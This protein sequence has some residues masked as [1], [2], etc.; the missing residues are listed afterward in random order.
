MSHAARSRATQ[1][2]QQWRSSLRTPWASKSILWI[3]VGSILLIAAIWLVTLQRIGTEVKEACAAAANT[4]AQVSASFNAHVDQTIHDADIVVRLVQYEYERSP[5]TFRLDALNTRGVISADTALQVTIVGPNGDV[6]QTTAHDANSINLRDRPHF[7]AHEQ[8][9][10]LGLYISR[11]LLGRISHHWTLQ[12]TR[13]LNRPDGSFAGVVVVSEDPNFLTTGFTELD[14]GGDGNMLA[15]L[16][17]NGYPLSRRVPGQ[18]PSPIGPSMPSYR[19]LLGAVGTLCSDPADHVRRFVTYRH[20][21]HYPVAVVVGMSASTAM[22]GYRHAKNLYLLFAGL[23]TA[24]LSIASGLITVNMGRLAAARARMQQL[25][26]TDALTGLPNRYLLTKSLH[27]RIASREPTGTLALLFVD[28]DN[29]KRINDAMGHQTGDE[30]LQNVAR[31]LARAAGTDALLARVG[32][33]EFVVVVENP[34]AGLAAQNLARSI[35]GAFDIAFGLRGNSYVMRVSIGI[36]VYDKDTE[37]EFDLLRRADLAMYAAKE[38]GKRTNVS[39]C[40]LYAPDLSTRAMREIEFQQ[41]LQYAID[42]E[43]FFVEYQP[44]VSLMTGR[45]RGLEA[46]VKW[47]HPEKG[48]LA[49]GDFIPFAE[50][51]GFIVPIGEQVLEQACRQFREWMD[52]GRAVPWLSVNVSTAQIVHGD[53]SSVVRRCLAE[54]DID[55]ERLKLEITQAV[56]LEGAAVVERTLHELREL[57]IGVILDDFG[58]GYSSLSQLTSLSVDGIKIDPG[59][60]RGIPGDRAAVA[61]L[62]HVVSLAR[63]LGLSIVVDGVEREQQAAWLGRLGDID[64]QGARFGNP[65]AP[66]ALFARNAA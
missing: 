27:Q 2:F 11:P 38:E 28:L 54:Y 58:T 16:S 21:A 9:P 53:L 47:R 59:F 37:A 63:D 56:L 30:L 39:V 24:V 42:N 17:D 34:D 23:L 22:A 55:P 35:L 45:T 62:E 1:W 13:R 31:R 40:R 3:P 6:L 25:A 5:S 57:G 26:E 8:D 64:V 50:T 20:S 10:K 61:T 48:V 66:D 51:T 18:P 4:T 49:H 15:V 19:E 52:R 41:E 44:I 7:I 65:A 32:G 60:T 46:L 36:A 43:E 33:D 12:F 14:G 29:F